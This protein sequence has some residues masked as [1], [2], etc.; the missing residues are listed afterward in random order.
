MKILLDVIFFPNQKMNELAHALDV[1]DNTKQLGLYEEFIVDGS[2]HMDL[3]NLCENICN[4]LEHK[5]G[6]SAN[7]TF[8]AITEI[9]GVPNKIYPPYIKEGVSSIS[10]GHHYGMFNELLEQ[11]GYVVETDDRVRVTSAYRK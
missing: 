9:D 10:N 5:E 2:E 11:L 8:I 1:F 7:V 6:G 4:S 3:E